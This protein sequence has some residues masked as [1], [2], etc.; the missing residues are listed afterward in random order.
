M[1]IGYNPLDACAKM[2]LI[3]FEANHLRLSKEK[4]ALHGNYPTIGMLLHKS[5]CA[6]NKY[7]H[8]TYVSDR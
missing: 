3:H 4:T 1:T 8:Y 7:T 5:T 2:A 6:S